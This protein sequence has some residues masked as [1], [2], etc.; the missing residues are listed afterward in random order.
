MGIKIRYKKEKIKI[1]GFYHSDDAGYKDTGIK[2]ERYGEHHIIPFRTYSSK[3]NTYSFLGSIQE[4]YKLQKVNKPLTFD[5]D[6]DINK[7]SNT[8]KSEAVSFTVNNQYL[9]FLNSAYN[10]KVID[11]KGG[12]LYTILKSSRLDLNIGEIISVFKD[13]IRDENK[14]QI[15]PMCKTIEVHVNQYGL[16]LRQFSDNDLKDLKIKS[17]IHL[18]PTKS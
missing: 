2:M 4:C 17:K 15:T 1:E 14:P 12:Y 18:K 9:F 13:R 11:F 3:G 6:F 16:D 5:F 10:F 8:P 7:E